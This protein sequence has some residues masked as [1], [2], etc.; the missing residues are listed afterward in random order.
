MLLTGRMLTEE[1]REAI[2]SGTTGRKDTEKTKKNKSIAFTGRKYVNP[3]RPPCKEE[4]KE[5]IANALT[6]RPGHIGISLPKFWHTP[7]GLIYKSVESKSSNDI[8][9]KP[10]PPRKPRG[11]WW[12]TPAGERYLA[13]EPRCKDDFPG[14]GNRKRPTVPRSERIAHEKCCIWH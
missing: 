14:L 6:G 7:E 11:S 8:R 3:R 9:G 12:H 1:H 13:V 2:R 10:K 5:K 4:T